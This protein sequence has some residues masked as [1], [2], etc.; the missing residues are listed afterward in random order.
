LSAHLATLAKELES[1]ANIQKLATAHGLSTL[2]QRKN[3]YVEPSLSQDRGK[4][5]RGARLLQS[6]DLSQI[7]SIREIDQFRLE[8]ERLEISLQIVD[9]LPPSYQ[10]RR[11]HA[12]AGLQPWPDRFRT[13]WSSAQSR[14]ATEAYKR[15]R[16]A[17]IPTVPVPERTVNEFLASN[18]YCFVAEVYRELDK[19]I[20]DANT[21][22]DPGSDRVGLLNGQPFA[23]YGS[24]LHAANICV[25]TVQF[26]PNG[27][28]EWSADEILGQRRNTLVTGAPGFGKSS[29]CRNHF[30]ADLEAFRT[31]QS[32]LK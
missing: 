13:E 4:L 16:N 18:A 6:S 19:Q 25:P 30:L 23:N 10:N 24:L 22:V 3:I 12:Q 29:F 32:S 9:Y 17:P 1:D 26:A 7:T 20:E 11:G 5:S 15:D 2:T 31:G 14:A 28:I 8:I 21:S 27:L